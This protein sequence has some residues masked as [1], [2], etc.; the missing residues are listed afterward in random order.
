MPNGKRGA[1]IEID[2]VKYVANIRRLTPE[3]CGKLQGVPDWYSWKGISDTQRY[4]MLGNGWQ[5]DTIKHCWSFLPDFGR[6]IRV[7]SLFDGMSC[8][9]IVLRELNIPVECF[10]SSEIDKY[11]IA[12][13]RQNFS[14]GYTS[15]QCN[16]HK[17][18]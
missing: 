2:G 14:R 11:A 5:C 12:A 7:W 4:K 10:V 17:C 6:P 16:G 13:E 3:E 1:E 18:G 9:G 8:A 15:W